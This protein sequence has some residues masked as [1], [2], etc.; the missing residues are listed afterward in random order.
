MVEK[1]SASTPR[2]LGIIYNAQSGRHR[3]RWGHHAP[4]AGV[5][6]IEANTTAEITAAV[7]ELAGLG[8]DLLAVAG[9][10]GTVQCVL[11]EILLKEHFAEPP[12]LALIPT[13]STNMTAR[14]AGAIN[15]RRR[16]WQPLCDWAAGQRSARLRQR[17]VLRIEPGGDRAAIAGMFF[18][19]GAVHHAVEHTQKRLH[20]V[21][22]RG[23]VGPALAFLRFL[24]SVLTGDGRHFAP[25]RLSLRDDKQQYMDDEALLMVAST[26]HRLV[27]RFHPFWGREDAAIAWTVIRHGANRLFWR[28]PLIVRGSSRAGRA[29]PID[30]LSHNSDTLELDFEG[31]FIVDGEFFRSAAAD[32]PVR[33]SVAGR[34]SFVSL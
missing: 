32:G 26:L 5:P 18:G 8:V 9:G 21:G 11:G 1:A 7:A 16:G 22:L 6:A 17:S 14:D 29:E 20:S 27:L 34:L 2:R 23:E 30:Y 4:P 31:G 15:V 12:L 25:T 10:D 28:I 19:A 24:K 3:R 33:L 13:G